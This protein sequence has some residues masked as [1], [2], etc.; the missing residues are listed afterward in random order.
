MQAGLPPGVAV[1]LAAPT[2]IDVGANL[3]QAAIQTVSPGALVGVLGTQLLIMPGAATS[4]TFGPTLSDAVSVFLLQL[5]ARYNVRVRVNG[6]DSIDD[7]T[8]ELPQ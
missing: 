4:L 2:Y 5:H 3:L 6:Y 7:T 1:T 8:L